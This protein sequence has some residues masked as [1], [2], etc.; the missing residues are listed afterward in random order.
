MPPEIT[1]SDNARVEAKDKWDRVS[2][3]PCQ[4]TVELTVSSFRV[5]DLGLLRVGK[6]L[7]SG[8]SLAKEVPVFA[9]G[10]LLGWGQFEAVGRHLGIRL[11]DLAEA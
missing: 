2:S 4:V 11:T 10:S 9:N 8:W 5:R 3:L 6:V 1:Q 7:D